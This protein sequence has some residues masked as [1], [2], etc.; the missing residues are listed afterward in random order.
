MHGFLSTKIS[1]L[2]RIC[3]SRAIFAPDEGR[4]GSQTAPRTSIRQHAAHD[5]ATSLL[6]RERMAKTG[7]D[8]I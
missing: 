1:Q 6:A 4:I 3:H 5:A 7:K 2:A 8:D